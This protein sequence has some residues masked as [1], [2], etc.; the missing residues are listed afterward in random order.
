[1]TNLG[2]LH[3]EASLHGKT[4]GKLQICSLR[5][6]PEGL[7][8]LTPSGLRGEAIW[9]SRGPLGTLQKLL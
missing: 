1:M 3:P 5:V 4:H 9:G 7:V 8:D 6:A 2:F